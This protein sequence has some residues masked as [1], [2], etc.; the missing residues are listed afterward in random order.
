[1]TRNK[2]AQGQVDVTIL[3]VEPIL[4]GSP[5]SSVKRTG[6]YEMREV[7]VVEKDYANSETK[8][9]RGRPRANVRN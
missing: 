2:S 8:V 3:I 9:P 7:K 4:I 5:G 1:M 6:L